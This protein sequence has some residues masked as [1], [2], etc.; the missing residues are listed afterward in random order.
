MRIYIASLIVGIIVGVLYNLL[1][2]RSPAP[3]T[4]ALVGLLGML[5]GEQAI[6]YVKQHFFNNGTQVSQIE[7]TGTQEDT[8]NQ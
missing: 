5:I 6:P 8:N 2:V 7:T 3:P 1:N 4:W